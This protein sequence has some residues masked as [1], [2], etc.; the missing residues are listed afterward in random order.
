MTERRPVVIIG[1]K[2]VQLP[3]GD[4]LPGAGGGVV[5]TLVDLTAAGSGTW[6]HPEPGVAYMIIGE[7]VGGGGGG[8]SGSA[9]TNTALT[10]TVAGG[11]AGGIGRMAYFEMVTAEDVPYTV[12]AGGAGGAARVRTAVTTGTTAGQGGGPGGD[13]TFGRF[14]AT[15]G[16]SGIQGSPPTAPSEA[17]IPFENGVIPEALAIAAPVTDL[18][19][20]GT[21]VTS[22]GNAYGGTGGRAYSASGAPNGGSAAWGSN[23][24]TTAT[25][26]GDASATDYGASGAGGG[27]ASITDVASTAKTATSGAGGDGAGGRIRF[28][29]WRIEG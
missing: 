14:K 9:K 12:G 19:T 27:A 11:S 18:G 23:V 29:Y 20:A 16:T 25:D 22:A 24:N 4:T 2:F 15:G 6:P 10:D 8:A 7:L 1:G 13:T 21:T 26:G 3:A 5:A 17:G 28:W